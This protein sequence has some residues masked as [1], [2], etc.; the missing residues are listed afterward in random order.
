MF[1]EIY[2]WNEEWENEINM[3]K[4]NYRMSL[5]FFLTVNPLMGKSIYL[6]IY[7]YILITIYKFYS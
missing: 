7:F 5:L 1:E 2:V 6:S 3:N 4:V